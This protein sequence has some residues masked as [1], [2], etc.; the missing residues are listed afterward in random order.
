M[1]QFGLKAFYKNHEETILAL[2]EQHRRCVWELANLTQELDVSETARKH[3]HQRRQETS[4]QSQPV[5]S[6]GSN[7]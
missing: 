3:F 4:D 2:R 7:D 1:F 5:Q 6:V